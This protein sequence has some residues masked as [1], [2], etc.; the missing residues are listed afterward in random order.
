MNVFGVPYNKAGNP[1]VPAS[2]A[3]AKQVM[4]E[5]AKAIVADMKDPGVKAALERGEI[6][7]IVAIIAYL[8]SLK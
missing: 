3:Q 6:K 4:L 2:Y 7:E 1:T 8:N 5:E